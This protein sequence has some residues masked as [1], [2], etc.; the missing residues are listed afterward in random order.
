M[1]SFQ[2]VVGYQETAC[3]DGGPILRWLLF[4]HPNNYTYMHFNHLKYNVT[5]IA[6]WNLAY[7]KEVKRNW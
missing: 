1:W 5:I 3:K 4:V 6:L 7:F 2:W